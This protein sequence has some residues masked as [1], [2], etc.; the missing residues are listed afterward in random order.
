MKKFTKR[1]PPPRRRPVKT[2]AQL[3]PA[4]KAA[5]T[6]AANKRLL[7]K[8]EVLERVG[9]VSFVSLW[10]W[11]RDGKFP[12]AREVGGQSAWLESDIDAWMQSRPLRQYKSREVA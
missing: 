11:M 3:E 4:L 9:G 8:D 12:V 10:R 1:P 7:F 2:A 6:V 5:S